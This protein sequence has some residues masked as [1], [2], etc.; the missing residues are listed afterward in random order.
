MT[1]IWFLDNY[2]QSNVL[3]DLPRVSRE[4]AVRF[5]AEPKALAKDREKEKSPSPTRSILC[6]L[7]Y[8]LNLFVFISP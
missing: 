8:C 2:I 7:L 3:I 1:Y 5:V 6:L 4:V